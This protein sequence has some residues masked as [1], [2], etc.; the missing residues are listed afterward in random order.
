MAGQTCQCGTSLMIFLRFLFSRAGL[1]LQTALFLGLG[2][3]LMS[4]H[5]GHRIDTLL[6]QFD[7]DG[8]G[9]DDLALIMVAFG[10][11]LEER[12]A[13]YKRLYKGDP[14]EAEKRLNG[15]AFIVGAYILMAGLFIEFLDQV[16]TFL[17]QYA[18]WLVQP[19]VVITILLHL[20]G[21]YVMARFL[22]DLIRGDRV[23]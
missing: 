12:E 23:S 5:I 13:L 1:I 6:G 17:I 21:L 11:L 20:A 9:E 22:W 18:A 15:Q 16:Q 14:S 4:H 7:P 2:I 3:V 19:S 10:V 8:P